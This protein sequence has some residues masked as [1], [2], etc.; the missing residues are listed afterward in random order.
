MIKAKELLNKMTQHLSDWLAM[1]RNPESTNGGKVLYGVANEVCDI[2]KAIEEYVKTFFIGNYIDKTHEIAYEYMQIHVGTI[3]ENLIKLKHPV[4]TV[5]NDIN[6]FANSCD[7]SYFEDGYLYFK[8]EQIGENEFVEYEIKGKTYTQ[9]TKRVQLWNVFD[10]FAL[11]VGLERRERENNEQLLERILYQSQHPVN[12]TAAGIQNAIANLTALQPK[13]II[14][15]KIDE[16]NAFTNDYTGRT[17]YEQLSEINRDCY[18]NK[19]WGLDYWHYDMDYNN[20][21]PHQYDVSPAFYQ[22][23]IGDNDDLKVATTKKDEKVHVQLKAYQK[24]EKVIQEFYKKYPLD[25]EMKIQLYKPDETLTPIE[26]EARID[27]GTLKEITNHSLKLKYTSA[28]TVNE[29]LDIQ[30]VLDTTNFT[31]E[32]P[33]RFQEGHLYRF[34]ITPQSIYSNFGAKILYDGDSLVEE[35]D[36]F[37]ENDLGLLAHHNTLLYVNHLYYFKEHDRFSHEPKGFKLKDQY[38]NG[39]LVLPLKHLNEKRIR[40]NVKNPTHAPIFESAISYKDFIQE[41]NTLSYINIPHKD[42]IF[43]IRERANGI[44]FKIEG[45]AIVFIRNPENPS[46]TKVKDNYFEIGQKNLSPQDYIIHIIPTDTT[47]QIRIS[48]IGYTYY[49][50]KI[51]LLE[52]QI[53]NNKLP[54]YDY[55]ELNIQVESRM[56][57][58]PLIHYIWIG[59]DDL[60]D[61]VYLSKTFTYETGKKVFFKGDEVFFAIE[62]LTSKTIKAIKDPCN[63]YISLKSQELALNLDAY[64]F[65]E[66]VSCKEGAP[67]IKR[68][69]QYFIILQEGQKISRII[70]KGEIIDTIKEYFLSDLLKAKSTS[71]YFISPVISSFIEVSQ[72]NVISTIDVTFDD[73]YGEYEIQNPDVLIPVFIQGKHHIESKHCKAPV[74]KFYLKMPNGKSYIAYNKQIMYEESMKNVMVDKNFNPLLP[75]NEILFYKIECLTPNARVVFYDKTQEDESEQESIYSIDLKPLNYSVKFNLTEQLKSLYQEVIFKFRLSKNI[76]LP[77]YITDTLGESLHLKEYLIAPEEGFE[78]SYT[79]PQA[80]DIALDPSLL[81]TEKFIIN[82]KTFRKLKCCH[83]NEII[84]IGFEPYTEN[85]QSQITE[86]KLIKQTGIMSFSSD[87]VN[88]NMGRIIYVHYTVKKPDHL[89]ASL[90]KLY[91]IKNVSHKAYMHVFTKDLVLKVGENVYKD[92][93][94]K[95]ADFVTASIQEPG[96]LVTVSP[97]QEI[98]TILENIPRNRI[99]VKKGFYYCDGEEYYRFGDTSNDLTEFKNEYIQAHNAQN[100]QEGLLFHTNSDNFICNSLFKTGPLAT[101]FSTNFSEL[102]NINYFKRLNACEQINLW[103]RYNAKVQLNKA[104]YGAGIEFGPDKE[105]ASHFI[106]LPIHQSGEDIVLSFWLKGNAEATICVQQP[107]ETEAH[108]TLTKP[109]EFIKMEREGYI[110]HADLPF[111]KNVFYYLMIS[112]NGVIDDIIL[113]DKT[114]YNTTLHQKNLTKMFIPIFESSKSPHHRLLFNHQKGYTGTMEMLRDGKVVPTSNLSY[115]YTM[116]LPDNWMTKSILTN[117][118]NY[119]NYIIPTGDNAS[120]LSPIIRIPNRDFVK[121]IIIRANFLNDTNMTLNIYTGNAEKTMRLTHSSLTSV[122]TLKEVRDYIQ[123]ECQLSEPLYSLD[124]SASYIEGATP[125][126]YSQNYFESE[127]FDIGY[128]SDFILKG[129]HFKSFGDLTMYIRVGKTDTLMD[130]YTQLNLDE[131]GNLEEA[132]QLGR[133]RYIQFKIYCQESFNLEYFDIKDIGEI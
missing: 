68:A 74:D 73:L 59:D 8:L 5:C 45:E 92:P 43:A 82:S 78:L 102:E 23:G 47:K 51:S 71:R 80:E 122:S 49:E 87:F 76:K 1:R 15:E 24:D 11:Y 112:G 132:Y 105:D 62:D 109:V 21:I 40:L 93:L 58:S 41:D 7:Y 113:C 91:D 85:A 4:A 106:G 128:I 38:R 125:E 35:K 63:Q 99:A 115:G 55:N 97:K 69:G 131:Y 20:Y 84:Y 37:Y 111:R 36:G 124:I 103:E 61:L 57:D 6:V 54:D 104:L 22:D 70:I 79:E 81:Q 28:R 14:V 32:P 26:V 3:D 108:L 25:T 121:E 119:E 18:R 101:L 130:S 60:A 88:Q 127:L 94:F 33:Y 133:I 66:S 95:S 67:L 34:K 107:L 126:I 120:I 86:Y 48:E 123:V 31:Q 12:S 29:E 2:E 77:R 9:A 110:Y 39:R 117:A 52:G 64:R 27:A 30:E 72:N 10:E 98:I 100:V 53:D 50:V 83:I 75:Y 90:D 116:L 56:P 42:S 17:L 89:V 96:Y 65:I 46:E 118:Q 16:Q 44:R 19:K 13:D 114:I 129:F